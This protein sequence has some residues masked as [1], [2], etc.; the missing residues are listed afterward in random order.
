M[1]PTSAVHSYPLHIGDLAAATQGLSLAERG[2]YRVLLDQYYAHEEPLPLDHREI[3][4]MAIAISPAERKSVDYV[5]KF[6]DKREDGYHQKRCDEEIAA[7]RERSESARRS[8]SARW[9]K[10]NTANN[11]NVPA[12]VSKAY[13]KRN[14]S[15]NQNHKPPI[16]PLGVRLEVWES[17]CRYR[18]AKLKGETLRLTLKHIAEWV[19]GGIDVNAMI[20][21]SIANGWKGLFPP[22]QTP[23][24]QGYV[25]STKVSL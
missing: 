4:R 2:A 13:V 16:A 11:T 19:A 24:A 9:N 21:K 7:Y 18:G 10:R 3:Y 8:V 22:D 15:L 1:S 12:N 23:A 20:E 5:L 6:F 25:P 14:T 17:W